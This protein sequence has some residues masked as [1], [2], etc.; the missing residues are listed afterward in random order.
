MGLHVVSFMEHWA[1]WR[2][3]GCH[4]PALNIPS[5]TG[6]L[7]DGMRSTRCPACSGE[8]RMP[9]WKIGSELAWIDPCPQCNGWGKI[10]G[11]LHVKQRTR[12]IDCPDCYDKEKDASLG[13]VQGRTCHRC[14]GSSERVFVF[15]Q[16]NPAGISATRY[17]GANED[18]DPISMMIDRNVAGWRNDHKTIMFH[19]VT[20]V[21]Y[22]VGGTQ[23]HKAETAKRY[24][25]RLTNYKRSKEISQ[26]W[27]SRTLDAAHV[28]IEVKLARMLDTHA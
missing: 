16:V 24:Y 22:T 10:R 28:L 3:N 4:G 6:K 18:D 11:D 5:L 19:L 2:S 21:E 1:R 23:A 27:F 9:G 25:R 26:S 12:T 17:A 14:R 8:G 13:E 7:M 20:I 15:L